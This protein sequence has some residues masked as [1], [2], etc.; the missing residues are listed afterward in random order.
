M[1][2]SKHLEELKNHTNEK[3]DYTYWT[4]IN[5]LMNSSAVSLKVEWGWF[6]E[7][8]LVTWEVVAV[9]LSP[10][11]FPRAYQCFKE[12]WEMLPIWKLL[13]SSET[14]HETH[15]LGKGSH[16]GNFPG[17][18]GWAWFGG[19]TISV[20]FKQQSKPGRYISVWK[21]GCNTWW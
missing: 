7:L 6:I 2:M 3:Q 4:V 10:A 19:T 15:P 8:D 1:T 16:W 14:C 18:R 13:S 9:I 11:H 20:G 17:F 5:I 21:V 12:S